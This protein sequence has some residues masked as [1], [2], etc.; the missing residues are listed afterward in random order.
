M[1]K[2]QK[3]IET[4]EETLI[5]KLRYEIRKRDSVIHN[6]RE[7]KENLRIAAVKLIGV[8]DKTAEEN[9]DHGESITGEYRV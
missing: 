1:K 5:R 9:L 7:S 3:Y 2:S 6:L 4:E 8:I